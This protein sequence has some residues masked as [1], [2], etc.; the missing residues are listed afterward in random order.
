MLEQ[1]EIAMLRLQ[2]GQEHE[3]APQPGGTG[4]W[5]WL[6]EEAIYHFFPWSARFLKQP[7]AF[8]AAGIGLAVVVTATWALAA[9]GE[10]GPAAVVGWWTGWS[11]YEIIVRTYCKPWVKEGPWWR[12]EFRPASKADLIAYVAT[13]NLL[14][15]AGLFLVLDLLGLLR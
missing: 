11:I 1:E 7:M 9:A 6:Y 12:R 10:V 2:T 4:L 15:G 14:I 8:K 5:R 3:P 13:K